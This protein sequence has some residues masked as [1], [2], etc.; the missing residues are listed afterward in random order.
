MDKKKDFELLFQNK[1][2]FFLKPRLYDNFS[3][4]DASGCDDCFPTVDPCTVVINNREVKYPDHGEIWSKTM[5]YE[6][7]PGKLKLWCDSEI[8]HYKYEKIISINKGI[9]NIDYKISNTGNLSFPCIWTMHELVNCENDMEIFLPPGVC[10]VVNVQNSS[11]FGESGKILS[12][13]ETYLSTGETYCLNRV[14]P[15]NAE[16]TEKFY[17]K[18]D[19][20][21][22]TCGVYFPTKDL[23]Y[24]IRFDKEQLPYL[25]LWITEGGFRGDY[26]FALE[27]SNGFYDN[28]DTAERNGK[29]KILQQGEVLSFNIEIEI[30]DGRYTLI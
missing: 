7:L 18:G 3:E 24:I 25:G 6:L 17:V 1:E 21:E 4:F 27:P 28:I 30:K 22:G 14:K 26:N 20:K 8:I 5:N 29:I 2:K 15:A 23:S 12:F 13:P 9:L 11:I 16:K 19:L 10:E